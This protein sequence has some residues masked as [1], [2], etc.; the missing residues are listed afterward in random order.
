MEPGLRL[1]SCL[2]QQSG[3]FF[4]QLMYGQLQ[5]PQVKRLQPRG[6]LNEWRVRLVNVVSNPHYP[7]PLIASQLEAFAEHVAATLLIYIP[8]DEDEPQAWGETRVT[9]DERCRYAI[10]I[11]SVFTE[12][13]FQP[14]W[15]KTSAQSRRYYNF[16]L[17]VTLLHELAHVAWR[18]RFWDDMIQN[19]DAEVGEAVLAPEEEQIELGQSWE[20]W[21]FGGELQPIDL[22]EE[23]PRWL[24]FTFIPFTIDSGNPESV[25]YPDCRYGGHAIPAYCI[26][27]FFQKDRWAAHRDTRAPFSIELTPLSSTTNEAWEGD[28]DAAFVGRMTLNYE[29]QAH[30]RPSF[31]EE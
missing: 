9:L 5:T 21:F 23:P 7:L 22:F 6:L 8:D 16:Q 24:G 26:N 29:D 11:G 10:G 27:Q 13:I 17:A 31:L 4:S 1:A 20:T 18:C 28:I 12:V 2:L 15:H 25:I 14:Q 3:P 19:P 30:P